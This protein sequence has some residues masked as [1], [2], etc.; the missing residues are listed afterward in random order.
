MSSNS[1]GGGLPPSW[2]NP[3]AMLDVRYLN[4]SYNALSG[5]VP[6]SWLQTAAFP[7]LMSL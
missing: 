5:S 4:I 3:A 1:L 6:G 2:G 7:T